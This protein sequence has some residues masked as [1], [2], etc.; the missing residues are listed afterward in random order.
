MQNAEYRQAMDVAETLPLLVAMWCFA[1]SDTLAAQVIKVVESLVAAGG[2][3]IPL[4]LVVSAN[5]P[6]HVLSVAEARK[7][8]HRLARIQ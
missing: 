7:G 5:R 3:E 1:E 2:A 6:L 4:A 8:I